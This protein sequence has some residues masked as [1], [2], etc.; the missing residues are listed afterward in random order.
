M[1]RMKKW[2]WIIGWV[3]TTLQSLEYLVITDCY[4]NDRLFECGGIW[5]EIRKILEAEGHTIRSVG[6][7][8]EYLEKDQRF[9]IWNRKVSLS[10]LQKY[11]KEQLIAWMWEPPSVILYEEEYFA[12]FGRI[13]SW[14]DDW[15]DGKRVFKWRLPVCYPMRE[16]VVPFAKRKLCCM[17]VANKHSTYRKELYSERRRAIRYFEQFPEEFD[18]YGG[19]WQKEGFKTYQ[20]SVEDKIA[21]TRGYKFSICYENTRGV[22]GYITEKIFDSFQAGVVPVYLGA[23]NITDEVPAGCFIDRRKFSSYQ[24]LHAY[25][26]NMGEEEFTQYLDN[27]RAFLATDAAKKYSGAWFAKSIA[28]GLLGRV[29]PE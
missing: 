22:P 11:P 2:G 5:G 10:Q 26:R 27:I 7:I 6:Q 17:V 9:V 13:L 21:A 8:P 18:L 3:C 14:Q 23:P 24:K 12:R 1:S 16:P 15:V 19:G 25:L 29:M 28:Y 20:G 4:P